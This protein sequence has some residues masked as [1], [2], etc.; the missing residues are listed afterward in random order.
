MNSPS[1]RFGEIECELVCRLRIKFLAGDR[2]KGEFTVDPPGGAL[3]VSVRRRR[4]ATRSSNKWYQ[5]R[6]VP[7][8]NVVLTTALG[9]STSSAIAWSFSTEEAADARGH[10]RAGGDVRL[11]ELSG[12]NAGRLHGVGD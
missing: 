9:D 6:L 12:A 5:S 8:G 3:F 10:R 2:R 11:R 7:G 1:D 4:G